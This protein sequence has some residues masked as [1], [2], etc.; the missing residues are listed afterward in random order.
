MSVQPPVFDCAMCGQCCEGEGGIVL[1][2]A[3]RERLC[4]RLQLDAQRFL[5]TC[6][7]TRNG[8]I[9]LRVKEDGHCLFFEEGQGCIVHEDK[10][11]VCKAWP[12]F[13]GNMVDASSL[14]LAKAYCPGIRAR[15]SYSAFVAEG[16]EYL[17]QSGLFAESAEDGRVLF[18]R[19]ELDAL[20][21]STPGQDGKNE[22]KA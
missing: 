12:F 11:A 8:K 16:V 22:R 6:T 19:E 7:D 17:R 13:R 10:P 15:L 4:R 1:S 9:R 21:A 18:T 5:D 3:D 20:A 2:Q 14:F